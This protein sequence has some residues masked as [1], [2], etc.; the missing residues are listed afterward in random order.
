[1][2]RRLP[3]GAPLLLGVVV[4]LLVAVLTA[5]GESAVEVG[6]G[7]VPGFAQQSPG[8]SQE[9]SPTERPDDE[10]PAAVRAIAAV[11]LVTIVL[12]MLA[13]ALLGLA[14]LLAGVRIGRR[15]RRGV[16]AAPLEAMDS[17]ARVDI[18]L[19][20]RVAGGA[21]DRLRRRE[22]GDPG[23]AVVLA[24]LALEEAAAES[25]TARRPHE[26]PTEFTTSVLGGLRVDVAAL[27][28][29]RG[30]YQ[31]ARFSRHAV[32]EDDVAAATAALDRVVDGLSGVRA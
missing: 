14:V 2:I 6:Q 18:E 16:T 17:E 32:T 25:G 31:R 1:M 3:P 5:G 26:T 19:M 24:W 23:D 8:G 12:G 30:L 20:R 9:P 11:M 29:L 4:L 21:L 15:R 10:T 13:L 7:W 22:G 28:E 27:D